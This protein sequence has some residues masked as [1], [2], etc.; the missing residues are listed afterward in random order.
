M[1]EGI[2]GCNDGYDPVR[3]ALS[4]K[5]KISK[6]VNNIEFRRYFRFRSGKWYGGIA[7]ADVIGCNLKC[8]FCWAWYFRDR[9]DLGILLSPQR[10][11]QKLDELARRY[12]Y[13]MVRL[14]GGEPTLTPDHLLFL[15]K[16]SN[17]YG[18]TFILETNGILIGYD[19]LLAKRI[20]NFDNVVV[21]VS[22]KG[23]RK[24]EFR[25]LTG[26]CSSAFE[27]QFRAL[28]NLLN[29]GL[30]PSKEL[31]VAVMVSF[32]EDRDIANFILKLSSI[33]KELVSSIDWELV[34]MYPH[35]RRI[36]RMYGLKPKRY[37][38]P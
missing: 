37:V 12:G 24:E 20:A 14:T 34:I 28:E 2:E 23:V 4:I 19:E 22:F 13:S 3:V 16:L 9:Y 5:P 17:E 29:Y 33:S 36:L 7:S 32:S 10:A 21:R 26:A 1:K 6:V 8:K 31:I 18:Y 38:N 30:T 11:M 27:Y 25:K 15:I 35:V